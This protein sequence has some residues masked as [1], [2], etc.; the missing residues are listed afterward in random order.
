MS[1]L[2]ADNFNIYGPAGAG[3]AR[4]QQGFWNGMLVT[5]PGFE[6]T[7]K[8]WMRV[9]ATSGFSAIRGLGGTFTEIGIASRFYFQQYPPAGN[10]NIHCLKNGLGQ[11]SIRLEAT[12]DGNIRV[13]NFAGTEVTRTV[14]PCFFPGTAHKIQAEYR[15][16]ATL[17]QVEV[18]IDGVAKIGGA[19]G[20]NGSNLV[21]TSNT[22]QIGVT[23]FAGS[24]ANDWYVDFMVPYSLTGTYNSSWPNISGVQQLQMTGAPI[25]NFPGRP[26]QLY[27]AGQIGTTGAFSALDCGTNTQYDL[28]SGDFTLEGW[29]RHNVFPT[30]TN[31]GHL[32][33]KWN[34]ATN[35]RSYRLI[36]NG[37]AISAGK[38]QFQISTDGTTGGIVTVWETSVPPTLVRGRWYHIAVSRTAAQTRVFINGIQIGVTKADANTYFATGTN[39]KMSYG[40]MMS[41]VTN[42]VVANTSVNGRYDEIRVTVGVGRYTANFSP[43]AG[44][45]PRNIGG[46]PSFASVQLL[47]GFDNAVVDESTTVPK[48]ITLR[49]QMFRDTPADASANYLSALP[50]D[51]VDERYIETP[52]LP[53]TNILQLTANPANG[54]QVVVGAT[55]YTFNTVLGAANSVLIGATFDD[56]LNNLMN[57]INLGAGIGVT[58][59]TGTVL[60]A[61]AF[62]FRG[63]TVNDMTG[64]AYTNGA[65]GN[66]IT[67][68]E[69]LA[70]GSWLGGAT[71]SG[72]ANIPSPSEY[73]IQ[74]LP[75][76]ATG[77]RAL[78][79]VDLSYVPSDNAT[80]QKSLVVSGVAAAGAANPLS[81]TPT[82]KGDVFEQDPNTG[83]ALTPTSVVNGR[84]R[85]ARTA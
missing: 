41:G 2:W 15:Y 77:L 14:T 50:L 84:I 61:S 51:P 73:T 69:T 65:A 29:Y 39:A 38:M 21:L 75:P 54:E 42:N 67:S 46:D 33:G 22:T 28:G 5:V 11:D 68:T 19:S 45:F 52:F 60:N 78:F 72:G 36:L 56:S 26:L 43:P 49:D 53:A 1:I 30:T 58:Y 79:V 47:A 20:I 71:F 40:G 6:T 31:I 13:I 17:G 7:G 64:Q 27:G 9:A 57:A 83:A 63:P 4:A 37:P 34:E 62:A 25:N 74:T 35:N 32:W 59:G 48:T 18:R 23:D 70:N 76:Q 12:N 55:T 85:L 66:T 10:A 3:D 81:T 80:L 16:H 82:Y 24:V 8:R 44:P